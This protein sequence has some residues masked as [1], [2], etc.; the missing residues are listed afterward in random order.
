[1]NEKVK[2]QEISSQIRYYKDFDPIVIEES[3]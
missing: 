2:S 3:S 1:M